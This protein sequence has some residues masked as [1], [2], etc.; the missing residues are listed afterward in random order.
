MQNDMRNKLIELINESIECDEHED[1]MNCKYNRELNCLNAMCA[2]HLLENGVMLPPCKIGDTVYVITTKIP[3]YACISCT[4]FC[5]KEC[6]YP[7]KGDWV[8]KTATVSFIEFGEIDRLRVE[9]EENKVTHS[10]DYTYWF[11]DIGKTVFLSREAAEEALKEKNNA[12]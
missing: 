9:I 6:P 7:D 12:E 11:D 3:C 10:Y 5:H 2:D 1:C 4:D 8:V